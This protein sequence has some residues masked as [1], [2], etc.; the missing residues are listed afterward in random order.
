MRST[1]SLS[2]LLVLLTLGCD[3]SSSDPAVGSGSEDETAERRVIAVIP[4]GTTHV[5]WR[6]VHA[7]ALRAANDLDVDIVWQGPV[8][9]DDRSAQIRV[10]E[11]MISRRVN[12]IVL[13]PLDDTALVP[14]AT[15][16]TREGIPVVIFD[17]GIEW[18]GRV[19]FVA[20]DN[21]QGG[22]LAA[23]RMNELLGGSGTVMVM[24]YQE[25]SASTSDRER[26]F[27]ETMRERFSGIQIV[28]DN[29]YGGATTETAYG[30]AENLLVSH[31]DV[32]GVFTPNES[33]TFGM[34]RALTDADRAGA[35][36]FVGFDANDNLV[37]ALRDGNIHGLVLQN[38]ERMGELGVRTAV[39]HLDGEE[40]EARIDTGATMVTRDNME[41]PAVAQLL[42]PDLSVL[43]D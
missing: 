35:V 29:Q 19:S 27:L 23:E 37:A 26:G 33:T 18:D 12:A 7:G 21:F 31:P 40:V 11:D 25:G 28:S 17:S 6:S 1:V 39:A 13:A 3:C 8:R 22:A 42:H 5:F 32:G 34:L 4:K 14:V 9:E 2:F 10:V 15:E 38:P 24:R 30:V 20:T 16:A 41:E 43:G 36:K